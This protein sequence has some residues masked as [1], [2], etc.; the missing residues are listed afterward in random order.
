[1]ITF[2]KYDHIER[3]GHPDV[4]GIDVGSVHVFPKLDGTCGSVWAGSNGE[5]CVA[6]RNKEISP[7]DD[8]HKFAAWV[9]TNKDR[10]SFLFSDYFVKERPLVI[11]GEWMVPHTLKTY[12]PDVWRRWWVFDVRSQAEHKYLPYEEYSELLKSLG[13]DIIEPLCTISDPTI[14]QLRALTTTNTYLIAEGAGLGE[15]IVIKN[16]AW[17]NKFG[18]QHWAKIVLDEYKAKQHRPTKVPEGE[19]K[20]ELEIAQEYCT[21]HLVGKTRAKIISELAQEMGVD[22]LEVNAQKRVEEYYRLKLIPRLIDT[23]YHDLVSE[24][25]WEIVKKY[26]DPIINFKELRVLCLNLTKEYAQDLF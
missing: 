4:E 24:S 10:F 3:L 16:Y 25:I 12:Q 22:L 18:H 11:Y 13:F 26:H 2:R 7:E 20:L 17:R 14:D 21:P 8:N 5:L 23:V 9:Q 1:M 19:F 15:G 6:S